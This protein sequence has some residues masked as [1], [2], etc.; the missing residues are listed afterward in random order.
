MKQTVWFCKIGSLENLAMPNG[1]DLPMRQAIQK[2]FEEITGVNAEFC[3]SGWGGELTESEIAC[4][5]NKQ[6]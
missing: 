2:A 1:A 6:P 3:F 4:V 5:L